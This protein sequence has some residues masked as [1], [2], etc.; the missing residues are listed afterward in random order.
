MTKEFNLSKYI[1]FQMGDEELTAEEV[2][3]MY[4]VKEFIRL[5]KERTCESP[6]ICGDLKKD[7]K[8]IID[9]LAGPG[10]I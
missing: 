1:M 7:L 2:I 9:K 8:E 6:Y 4:K 5:L 3:P 10:L